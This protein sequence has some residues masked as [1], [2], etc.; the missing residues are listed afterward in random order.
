M[1]NKRKGK[2]LAYTS[3]FVTI[4]FSIVFFVKFLV[5]TSVGADNQKVSIEVNLDKYINYEISDQDKGTLVEYNVRTGIEYG[6]GDYIPL[7]S[8]ELAISLNQIDGKYPYA[9]KIITKS[10]ESTNGKTENV[11]DNYEYDS[12]TGTII[13]RA[14]N[15]DENG[16]II[17]NT[18]PSDKAKDEY[19]IIAYYDTYVA[20]EEEREL[21]IK[22]QSTVTLSTDDRQISQENEFKGIVKDNIG[23]LTSV[24]SEAGE[25]YNGYIKSNIINGTNYDTEYKETT[26]IMVSKK[27]AQQKI[28]FKESNSFEILYQNSNGE[29][30]TQEFASNNDLVYKS[31]KIK[32]QDIKKILGENGV[33]EILDGSENLIATIDENTQFAEDGSIVI[34]YENELESIIIKTSNIENE[35][36]LAIENT[37]KI[38]GTMRNIDYTKIKTSNQIIGINEEIV[39]NGEEET[40]EEKIIF[41]NDYE[42]TTDIK[43]S[44]NNI[45]IDISNTE[46]TNKYQ[47]EVTFNVY[48]SSNSIKDNML[49][50]PSIRIELPSEV[51]KVILGE[52]SVV[53][54]NGLELQDPYLETGENGNIVIVANLLGTQTGYNENTLGLVTDVKISATIILKKDIE[55]TTGNINLTYTN[56]YTV[57]GKA[58]IENR[59]SEIKIASYKEENVVEDDSSIVTHANTSLLGSTVENIEGLTV[60]VTPVRGDTVLKDGDT[61]YEGEFIKY[62]IKVT[63]TSDK[64]I[65]NIK[66]VGSIPEGTTYGELEADYYTST[67]K[68]QYNYDD[69]VTEKAIEIGSLETGK[70]VTKFYEVQVND[71]LEGQDEQEII[72]NVKVYAEQ[73]QV[74]D[75]SMTNVIKKAE[76]KVFLGAF[77]GSEKNAWDYT[78]LVSSDEI[79]EVTATVKV[80]K[81]FNLEYIFIDPNY[82]G[83]GLKLDLNEIATVEEDCIKVK[84][85]TNKKYL[86]AGYMN[87]TELEGEIEGAEL[88]LTAIANVEIGNVTYSS[89]ENRIL[90]GYDSVSILMTSE[91]EGEEVRYGNEINYEIVVTNTGNPNF[92][93]ESSSSIGVH[94][95]DFLPEDVEPVKITYNKY[96]EEKA[97]EEKDTNEQLYSFESTGIYKEEETVIEDIGMLTDEEGNRLPNVDLYLTI[98]YGKS[99]T[100]KVETTAGLVFEKTKIENS[101]T[102]SG[103]LEEDNIQSKTSNT[104]AHAILPYD[105]DESEEPDT[106]DNPDDPSDPSDPSDPDEPSDPSDN[107][108]KYSIAGVA[109]LDENEDGKRQTSEELLNGITVMLVNTNNSSAIQAKQVT[110]SNGA[111]RFSGLEEGNYIVVFNYDTDVYS[112]TEYQKSGV[113]SS[114]NSDAISKEITLMGVKTKVGLTDTISLN[115][116][117][118]NIDMGLIKNKICDLKLDKYISKVQVRTTSG[119]KEYTYDNNQL[120]K[121]E[122]KSKEIQGA[123]VVVTY[124]IVVTNEGEL[125][126]YATKVVDYVPEG[127]EFSSNLNSSW[128]T[129][130]SGELTNIS[131]A[132]RRIE[133]GESVELTLVLTKSMTSNSTGTFT[134]IAEIGEMRNS[135]GTSDIDSTPGNKI[136]TEDDF[137][138]AD[139]IISVSTGALIYISIGILL[140]A[141]VGVAIFLSYKYGILKISK[142]S[143][144]GIVI[145]LTLVAGSNNV[146]AGAPRSA[147]FTWTSD[148]HGYYNN[149]G[150]R[151]FYGNSNT[152]DALCIQ[153]GVGVAGA[154]STYSFSSYGG[155]A[156][157]EDVD[158]EASELKFDL[159]NLN[160]DEGIE[161]KN[162]TVSGIT[163]KNLGQFKFKCSS[164]EAEFEI[165]VYNYNKEKIYCEPW[166]LVNNGMV[167]V[168]GTNKFKIQEEYKNKEIEFSV[169]VKPEDYENG[170]AYVELT[171]KTSAVVKEGQNVYR[172]AE[173]TYNSVTQD[174]RTFRK[175]LD[176]NKSDVE[177]KN[178]SNK[179]SIKWMNFK[180]NLKI[181]KEDV[182]TGERLKGVRFSVEGPNISREYVTRDNGEINLE[183]IS[184]GSYTIKEIS[185]PNYGYTIMVQDSIKVKSAQT[186]IYYANNEK[187]TGNLHI[188]KK[189][190]YTEKPLEGISFKIKADVEIDATRVDINQDKDVDI[191]DVTAL[192][193]YIAGSIRTSGNF[194]NDKVTP[195]GLGDLNNDGTID[196]DDV[197][198]L[199]TYMS[200]TN[201]YVVVTDSSDE[202]KGKEVTGSISLTNM[203]ITADSDEATTFTTDDKGEINVLNMLTGD[204][205]LEETSV[206]QKEFGYDVDGE[207]ISYEYTNDGG[208]TITSEEGKNN[209]P[210]T[211]IRQESTE[212][213]VNPYSQNIT[214]S[215]VLNVYNRRKYIKLSGYVWEDLISQKG[216]VKNYLWNAIEYDAEGNPI[217]D[218]NGNF[219][220]DND[221]RV[222][223]VTV[224]LIKA[225]GTELAKTTT[226]TIT[227]TKGEKEDGAYLFGDY[228]RDS[229]AKKI[230]ID[231]LEG[232]RIEFEY[233]GMCYQSIEVNTDIDNGNKATEGTE[234]TDMNN[235]YAKVDYTTESLKG[236][237]YGTDSN[238]YDLD[239]SSSGNTSTLK[240]G[241]EAN[242]LYGYEG[243][244][245]PIANV[246]KQYLITADTKR[247]APNNLLGQKMTKEYILTKGIEEIPNINL[248]LEQREQPDLAVKKD[249][250]SAHVTV[251][252]KDHT[253]M[254]DARSD[255]SWDGDGFDVGVK[256]GNKYGTIP[257]TLPIYAS[258]VKDTDVQDFKV[259]VIYKITLK[260]ESTNLTS[261]VYSLLDYYDVRYRLEG[262][263]TE[264]GDD[265]HI[266]QNI[267]YKVVDYNEKY[268][269]AT[270]EVNQEIVPNEKDVDIYIEFSLSKKNARQILFDT[271]G[272]EIDENER[273][274][275]ENIAE[276]GSYATY[277]DGKLY[278]GVDKD[279][280]PGSVEPDNYTKED[281]TD[282][283][284]D[285][286]LVVADARKITGTVFLDFTPD[287]LM[288][289]EKRNGDGIFNENEDTSIPNVTVKMINTDGDTAKLYYYTDADGTHYKYTEEDYNKDPDKV[290]LDSQG[291]YYKDAI[292]KTD[293]NGD[294]EFSGFI[295]GTYQIVYI[296]GEEGYN[297]NDY[298]CTI[299]KES[300]RQSNPVWYLDE[301]PRYSDA[302]DN[303][304][305]RIDID[306]GQHP[307]ITTMDST[308]PSMEMGI[309]LKDI[310]EGNVTQVSNI[311][312]LQFSIPNID[313]GIAERP[314]QVLKT[315]KRV[316]SVKV[317]LANGQTIVDAQVEEDENGELKLVGNTAK[318]VT[319][320]APS[321]DNEPKNGLI[322]AEIDNELIQG[323]TIQ[324]E[325]EIKVKNDS[326]IDYASEHY[327]KYGTLDKNEKEEDTLIKITPSGVYDYLDREMTLDEENNSTTWETKTIQDYNRVVTEPTML[328]QYLYEYE[329]S[330]IDSEGVI[331]TI[332]GYESF[333]E[334]Y[335]KA[336]TEWKKETI[337]TAREKRLADKTI[338]H[339][340]DLEQE[341]GPLEEN[342]VTLHTSKVLANTDEIELNNDVEVTKVSRK[343]QTGRKVTPKSS[344]FYAK[345]ETIVITTPTGE[346]KNYATIITIISS[347]IIL[348]TGI[349]F[350]KKKILG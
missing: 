152:G 145:M 121:V 122:I 113:S 270:L 90:Y 151:Y 335:Q 21:A 244:E 161:V 170:I 158:D 40:K 181:I 30:T 309:E 15:E 103:I 263:G 328:E 92:Q 97:S 205:L 49:K 56:Y 331:T 60:E 350:I 24:T 256:F 326:E 199:Q 124:K 293:E 4:C 318:G 322:R 207:Y 43:E 347:F 198:L 169:S 177:E 64:Q 109:W 344:V 343:Q 252:G 227:N 259:S 34:S 254:Y 269:K 80:P 292:T 340:T 81:E 10:T 71:L 54:A 238:T 281:D 247:A 338:L 114:L 127:L 20:Q 18:R 120:A 192:Q 294:F 235:M 297:V 277:R 246:N 176:E 144:F 228:L 324:I 337:Q 123:T 157:Y 306:S 194:R 329:S 59:S 29:E 243:Q 204:Y 202:Y 112:I 209:I 87:R 319:Y 241:N 214:Y 267:S 156:S 159:T 220:T 137:S 245:F 190:K 295:P 104:I 27:E 74:M 298:K 149:Y 251:N 229:S 31:T 48:I 240:Y 72:T 110:D 84:V 62:N 312:S 119:T 12:N 276:I 135:L 11:E 206:G 327:Y 180:G 37:K 171:A 275:L 99:V 173:Y 273:V 19:I 242:Y 196:N 231:D 313:F 141:L 160:A 290:K 102:V 83:G 50:D 94:V 42:N 211:I 125:P 140:V 348:G 223:N 172:Q 165:H 317:T 305:T 115:A 95:I 98:P 237:A 32:Q 233:N 128:T 212:T 346:N 234:R 179:K 17:N 249:T 163:M 47:N 213:G 341:I 136:E 1:V 323:S 108:E 265:G 130:K 63:N 143:L 225:D 117:L 210:F 118:S 287:E 182:E 291:N 187:Q 216:S 184:V 289:N 5:N 185:N 45:N 155:S 266:K 315:S 250:Y 86:I 178:I 79:D 201:P 195:Y 307:E 70:S 299:Y 111:Y 132:N 36:I 75:Y 304:D 78:L 193:A 7:K 76:V 91:S 3:L 208:K 167:F 296:W 142:I 230:K 126:A 336:V 93:D 148:S 77:L 321:P 333:M 67:G 285:L 138:K 314:R 222:N 35:G 85:Q 320:M 139:L 260:N 39:T 164:S 248:G 101:A 300:S 73:V 279:S 53:Y 274:L 23:E 96:T 339:T 66:V 65:D 13:I 197:I 308:T 325:Y 8:S 162:Q 68:Y 226:Q 14:N 131:I 257:Y 58:E 345:A 38:K 51:E 89:N 33:I 219:V 147:Q 253:Y 153:A 334:Q 255:G 134:N 303:W 57:N 61:V 154:G 239:Y 280:R 330:S 26:K 6:D 286:K 310:K 271:N 221:K 349:V 16:E 100:I 175:F 22:V 116:S 105:Y 88:E 106:P 301:K 272:D 55:N 283:A 332:T 186:V 268:N 82:E 2:I 174:V 217:K 146:D 191:N 258:D 284:P 69:T 200:G 189:D 264:I 261:K 28:G 52:S 44:A 188:E 46:W 218:E 236:I 168:E 133:A 282:K 9:V 311:N 288:T 342:S 129:T 262:V 107:I 150:S 232:A 166:H 25:I 215:N 183:N 302:I 203:A 278:A 316:K 224:R 41:T